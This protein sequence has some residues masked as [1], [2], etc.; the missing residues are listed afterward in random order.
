LWR[1]LPRQV[2]ASP[3]ICREVALLREDRTSRCRD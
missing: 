1:E 3:G 2:A